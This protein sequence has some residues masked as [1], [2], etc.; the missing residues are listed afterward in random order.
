MYAHLHVLS[1][2]KIWILRFALFIACLLFAQ[3]MARGAVEP[4]G[5]AEGLTGTVQVERQGKTSAA[6]TGDPVFLGDRWKTLAESGLE[7]VFL[8]Q[9]RVK[10]TA[11][12]TLEITEYLYKPDEKTRQGLL[13]MVSGKA[14]FVVQDLQEFKDKRFR[15]Q[16]QTAVVGTR[17][18]DFAVWVVDE[19]HT[20]AY[21]IQNSITFQD[22]GLIGA[23]V[24]L[25]PNMVSEVQGLNAAT[26]PR[27]ATGAE[28]R[29]FMRGIE[30]IGGENAPKVGRGKTA[31]GEGSNGGTG[32]GSSGPTVPGAA[33][34]FSTSTTLGTTTT[35]ATTTTVAAP[36]KVVTSSTTSSTTT[37][38]TTTTTTSTTTTR[39][40]LPPPP[41]VP[42]TATRGGAT[43]APF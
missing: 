42:G 3:G 35:L 24:I 34:G 1:G 2:R 22:K 20:K 12:T 25:T 37:T 19:N 33:P 30:A 14:R 32:D 13:S 31:R 41:T 18:T 8:D 26:R 38:T 27:F 36:F 4:V 5:K 23:G 9:S 39:P 29:Q 40:T 28:Q 16:T 11:G 10:M 6:K 43:R 21:C 15:V 17:D 7:I